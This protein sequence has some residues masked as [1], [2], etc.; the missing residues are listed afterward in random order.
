MQPTPHQVS[1]LL[2]NLWR[3]AVTFQIEVTSDN[4]TSVEEIEIIK[5]N[6]MS[7]LK[8]SPTPRHFT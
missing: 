8:I 7:K 6:P 5:N 3:K 1:K 2:D 4:A